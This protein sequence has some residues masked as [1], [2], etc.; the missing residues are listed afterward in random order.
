VHAVTRTIVVGDVH[1]CLEE[2]DELLRALQCGED[3]RLIFAGDLMD[4]GPDPV[5]V[6]RRV[7]E[8]GAACVQGN[9]DEKHVRW[10]RHEA[11]RRADAKYK[12]PMR[13]SPERQKDNAALRDED[14]AW[15]GALPKMIKL[16]EKWIVVHAGLEAGLP[17]A[18]QKEAAMLRLRYVDARGRFL[19]IKGPGDMP[20]GGAIWATRWTGPESVIYGHAVHDLATP[21]HDEPTAGVECWGIDTGCC[22]GGRLTAFLPA[23]KEIVQVAAKQKYA[24]LAVEE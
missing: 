10:A 20:E 17:L 19:A 2:L 9:H 1:G 8:L 22:F 5:G 18:R 6:V 21:R 14:V 11:K 24:E 15:L 7:R 13:M 4:R 23:T 16:D 12:N 3:D